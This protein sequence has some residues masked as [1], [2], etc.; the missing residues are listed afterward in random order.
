MKKLLILIMSIILTLSLTS[1][2]LDEM[3]KGEKGEKGDAG[4][5]GSKGDKGDKGDTGEDGRGILKLEILDGYLWVT[6][7][8]EPD[9]PINVGKITP[10]TDS[11]GTDGLE[12]YPL[13]DGSLSVSI[14]TSKYLEKIIIPTTYNSKPITKIEP[15]AFKAAENLREAVIPEGVREIGKSAFSGCAKLESIVIPKSVEKIGDSAFWGCAKLESITLPFIGET[16]AGTTNTA[17]S[18]V[19]GGEIPSSL[20]EVTVT[21]SEMIPASAFAGCTSL[22]KITLS[23]TVKEIGNDAFRGCSKIETAILGSSLVTVGDNAFK[24]C[25]ALTAISLPDSLRSIGKYAFAYCSRLYSIEIPDGMSAISYGAFENCKKL[26]T[27][28]IPSSVAT[29]GEYAFN[30]CD[31]LVTVDMSGVKTVCNYAFYDCDSLHRVTIPNTI[32]SIANFAFEYCDKLVEVINESELNI[33]VGSMSY[34]YVAYYAF[35]VHNG[36]SNLER[37]GDFYFYTFGGKN[38]LV[39]YVGTE[40]SVTLPEYFGMESYEIYD[41]A[42]ADNSEI[43]SI[44]IPTTVSRV[45]YRAFYGCDNLFIYCKAT[46]LPSG[47]DSMWNSSLRPVKWGY[48]G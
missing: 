12:Y 27:V 30:N 11:Y 3:S 36:E 38:Y 7:T 24:D 44:V 34:G 26:S 39:S 9:S 47:W 42:F 14:G 31:S 16:D 23:D 8:D 33:T 48:T 17:F 40:K 4:A 45:G 1:C 6:Y 35:E 22:K 19:F 32:E 5:V 43:T 20:K 10:D 25:S 41:Y 13:P 37:S 46:S 28:Y 21:N 2:F 18:Y 29:I 15:N